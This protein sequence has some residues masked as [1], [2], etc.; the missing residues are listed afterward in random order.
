MN[1][2]AAMSPDSVV[3]WH[4]LMPGALLPTVPVLGRELTY[5][6][7]ASA[8]FEAWADQF[9]D[10][11]FGPLAGA[12]T[13]A[14]RELGLEEIQDGV[15]L[16][17]DFDTE[18]CPEA[19]ECQYAAYRLCLAHWYSRATSR[20]LSA[21]EAAVCLYLG[22]PGGPAGGPL[23]VPPAVLVELGEASAVEFA[24]RNR[25]AVDGLYGELMPSRARRA[26]CWQRAVRGTARVFPLLVRPDT[27]IG[28]GHLVYGAVPPPPPV[29]GRARPAREGW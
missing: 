27:G 10:V 4:R 11:R 18:E 25:P 23:P 13:W 1:D 15:G 24:D 16:V 5:P 14:V 7:V 6:E 17:T 26:S 9:A 28:S 12:V 29:P 21:G 3:L 20:P 2:P 19:A 8:L 22:H